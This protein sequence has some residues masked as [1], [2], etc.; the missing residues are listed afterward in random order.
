MSFPQRVNGLIEAIIH[1]KHQRGDAPSQDS[2]GQRRFGGNEGSNLSEVTITERCNQGFDGG[3]G[4]P[5]WACSY[6]TPYTPKTL[7][8][9]PGLRVVP[10]IALQNGVLDVVAMAAAQL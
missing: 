10:K 9:L 6:F 3:H 7:H 5:P 4:L 1:R 8:R 2:P